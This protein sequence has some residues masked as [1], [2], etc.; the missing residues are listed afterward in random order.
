MDISSNIIY[1]S[2]DDLNQG[3]DSAVQKY[4]D[5]SRHYLNFDPL[6]LR[7]F[8]TFL[9][10]CNKFFHYKFPENINEY[11]FRL[12]EAPLIWIC[13]SPLNKYIKD[14]YVHNFPILN[15]VDQ[16]KGVREIYNKWLTNKYDDQKKYFA[17]SIIDFVE[18]YNSR[19]NF[20]S[21]I[22][23]GIVLLYDKDIFN[24]QRS[25]ELFDKSK[26]IIG[27][28]KLTE[29][30]KKELRYLVTLFSGY[31]YI[32][33]KENEFARDTFEDALR[34]KSSGISAKFNLALA[35]TRLQNFERIEE[36]I[37][38]IYSYDYERINFA[39]ENLS[40][41]LF[42]YYIEN[43]VFNNL[44]YYPEFSHFNESIES[45]LSLIRVSNEPIIKVLTNK[46]ELFNIAVDKETLTEE[47]RKIIFFI[48]K[49]IK[50]YGDSDNIYYLNTAEKLKN[51]FIKTVRKIIENAK[52]K[53]YSK[54]EEIVSPINMEI[55]SKTA[56]I[57]ELTQELEKQKLEIKI[58]L[59]AGI[60]AIEKKTA[61]DIRA[62]EEGIEN[63]SLKPKLNPQIAFKHAMIY[64]IILSFIVFLMGGCA[65]YSNNF[66]HDVSE[67]KNL[68][69]ISLVTGI[70]WGVITFLVGII[71][72]AF[73][74]GFAILERS[75]RRQQLLHNISRLKNDKEYKINYFKKDIAQK[76]ATLIKNF[77]IPIGEN[78]D[79]IDM[80]KKQLEAKVSEMKEQ[81]D[82][83]ITEEIK[84][85]EFLLD[86]DN[87][88]KKSKNNVKIINSK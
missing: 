4:F 27:K 48:E 40:F 7:D 56:V 9:K 36:Y 50:K 77:N 73:S 21:N 16:Y 39:I 70:K 41:N 69:S 23:A 20:L 80:L 5:I 78:K 32:I 74:A 68:I 45:F 10:N 31:S 81:A 59:D 64:N 14:F 1:K 12:E 13:D 11:F 3:L 86:E 35:D 49:A 33:Q 37:K 51:L 8:Q 55:S 24:P 47:T 43:A 62:L 19:S 34:L 15:G 87:T 76:E 52:N 65:G 79:R 58:K 63:L 17:T 22:L 72:S 54:I 38:E 6:S 44:F 75:N 71:V 82:K 66:V 88:D 26:E 29:S 25:I 42:A 53:Y 61:D 57:E 67:L 46:F 60:K 2:D 18:N 84:P 30:A 83:M 28:I 85:F